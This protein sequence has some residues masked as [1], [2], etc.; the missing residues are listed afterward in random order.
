MNLICRLVHKH[1]ECIN[2]NG[3][4]F[5]FCEKCDDVF[6]GNRVNVINLLHRTEGMSKNQARRLLK[7]GALKCH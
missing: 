4:K 6:K 7:Q 2:D 5:M 3:K 1:I